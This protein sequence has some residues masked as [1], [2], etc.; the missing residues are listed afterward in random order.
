[1]GSPPSVGYTLHLPTKPYHMKGSISQRSPGSWTIRYDAP[2]LNGK[3]KQLTRTVR[4][5]KAQAQRELT[6]LLHEI[7]TG[8]FAEP[9][10]ITVAEYLDRWLQEHASQVRPTTLETYERL[11][12]CHLVP[13]LGHILLHQLHPL[14]I[15]SAYTAMLREGRIDRTGGL[16]ARAVVAIHRILRAALH[17]AVRWGMLQRNPADMVDPPRVTHEERPILD[18]GDIERLLQAA[19]G[20]WLW[21][22]ILIAVTTGMRRGE[23]LGLRWEDVDLAGAVLRV[24]QERQKVGG[25]LMFTPPKTPKSR[26]EVTLPT[27]LVDELRREKGRQA[28]ER[29]R[30]GPLWTDSGLVVTKEDGTPR[31]PDNLTHAFGKLV[32]KA[33]VRDVTFHDLRHSHSAHLMPHVH[34]LV[35]SQ[36]LG[37]ASSDIT[38]RLYGHLL[39]GA[40][41]TAAHAT[42]AGVGAMTRRR[43]DG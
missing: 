11:T 10:R 32:A 22:P 21:L 16:S 23:I 38:L 29:L 34:L 3:R 24:R 27:L 6:R 2:S 1:M 20:S 39:P 42:E 25:R 43:G 5:T 40:Q 36:R 33:G 41:E 28:E 14:H 13:R 12:R 18:A 30:L 15:Q 4:G 7:A 9:E 17:Q 31:S 35:I 8:G 26:R 37:H 19:D